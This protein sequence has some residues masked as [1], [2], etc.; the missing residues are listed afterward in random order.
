MTSLEREIRMDHERVVTATPPGPLH[1][2]PADAVETAASRQPGRPFVAGRSS[3]PTRPGRLIGAF[4]AAALLALTALFAAPM[5][6]SAQ[7]DIWS[8][9]SYSRILVTV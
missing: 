2:C 8:A 5:P 6:A 7:S 3:R 4:A 1:A 9:T